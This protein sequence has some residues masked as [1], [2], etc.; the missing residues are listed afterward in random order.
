[1]KNSRLILGIVLSL[2]SVFGTTIGF[3]DTTSSGSESTT[4][5]SLTL[6]L[7]AAAA[8]DVTIN[9]TV[10]ASSTAKNYPTGYYDINLPNGVATITAGQTTTTIDFTVVDDTRDEDNE[11]VIIDIYAPTNATLDAAASQ[12]TYTINDNDNPPDMKFQ[13]STST[14]SEGAWATVTVELTAASG[15]TVTADWTL[16]DVTTSSSDYSTN[17]GTI[18]ITEGY[19]SYNFGI[20]LYDDGLDEDDESFTLSL[21]NFSNAGSASPST[22]E[23][24]ITDINDPPTVGFSSSSTSK[25]ESDGAVSVFVDLDNVSGRNVTVNYS[26]SGTATGSNIDHDLSAGTATITA[27]N[28]STTID[29]NI[30]Q[31]AL[32][33]DNETI[34][35]ILSSASNAT[36]G[37][38]DTMTVTILDDDASPFVSF[39]AASSSG[40]ESSSPADLTVTLNPVSGRSVQVNYTVTGGTASGSGTD[41][42]LSNGTLTFPAE[43]TSKNISAII[44]DDNLAEDNETIEVTISSPTNATLGTNTVHTYTINDNDS[45]PTIGFSSST[46]TSSEGDGQVGI[47]IALSAVSGQ[48]ITFDYAITGGTATSGSDYTFTPGAATISAGNSDTTITV[49]LIDDALDEID[50]ETIE[51]TI[52]NV[53]N[54]SLTNATH[55]KTITDNDNAPTVQFTSNPAASSGSEASSPV[56]LAVVIS[57][58]SAL[59][60]SVAY[61]IG[62]GSTATGSGTDYTLSSGTLTIPAGDSTGVISFTVNNDAL[63]ENDETV[64]VQ[65]SNPNNSTLGTRSSYTYTISDDDNSPDILF[66]SSSASGAENAT[67]VTIPVNITAVSG[68]GV[69]VDYTVTGGTALGSGTDYTL[70]DGSLTIPAGSTSDNISLTVVDDALDENSETIIVELSNP[71]NAGLGTTTLYTYTITD[72]DATPQIDFSSATGSVAE[73]AGTASITVVLNAVSGLDA[74][75]NYAVTGGDATG[76]GTDYTLASGIAT[77]TA[78]SNSTTIDVNITD[79]SMDERDE[80]LVISLSSPTN[81]TIGPDTTLTLTITDNDNPVKIAFSSS[82]SSVTENTS[83]SAVTVSLSAVSGVTTSVDYSVTDGTATG[84]G[85]DY[86]LSAGTV[87]IP[88]GDLSTTFDVSINDDNLDEDNETVIITLANP[89]SADL[90][91]RTNFTLTILDNDDSPTIQLSSSTSSASEGDGSTTFQLELSAIS[92]RDVMVDHVYTENEAL[93]AGVDF[94]LSVGTD[95]IS[96]GSLTSIFTLSLV[97]DALDEDDETM[98]VDIQNPVNASLG[99]NQSNTLTI[100]DNDPLPTVGFSASTASGDEATTSV[101]LNVVLSPVSGRTVTVEYSAGTGT[102]TGSGTDFSFTNGSLTFAAGETSKSLALTIADD[103]LDEVDE[104]VLIVLNNPGQASL[105]TDTLTYTIQDNDDPPVVA[106]DLVSST[107]LESVDSIYFDVSLTAASGKDVSVGYTVSSS[108]TASG[109]SVDYNLPAGTL[110]F[111]AGTTTRSILATIINDQLDEDNE[112]IIVE[113][114]DPPT[115]AT[116]GTNNAHTYTIIDNDASPVDFT[117]GSVRSQGTPSLAGFWNNSNTGLIV[118]V[119][120]DND[121]VL[122]SG[123]IQIRARSGSN[124]YRNLGSAYTILNSDLNDSASVPITQSEFEAFSDFAENAEIEFTAVITDIYG[125]STT[126]TASSETIII[127]TTPPG[128]FNTESFAAVGGLEVT[129]YWNGTNTSISA[130]VQ[131]QDDT[132]LPGGYVYL[133]G[134]I[135]NANYSQIGDSTGILSGDLNTS[136]TLTAPAADIQALTGYQAENV[137]LWLNSVII[138]RAGNQRTGN[139]SATLLQIDSNSPTVSQVSSPAANLAYK[140]G[141]SLVIQITATENIYVTGTPRLTLETGSSDASINYS[142]GS[143]STTIEFEYVVGA[144]QTSADLDYA[145]A[146]ALSLNGGTIRDVGGND[147]ILTLPV[148]GAAGSLSANNDIIIDTDAPAASL[149][150]ADSLVRFEDGS[151]LITATF[152]DSMSLDSVPKISVTFPGSGSPDISDASLTFVSGTVWQYNLGLIDNVDGTIIVSMTGKDKALNDLPGSSVSGGNILRIDNTDPVFTSVS[153]D[154]GSY[155]NH[156]QVGWT[157]SE[158]CYSGTVSFNNISGPGSSVSAAL[159]GSELSAGSRNPA[160]ITNSS[161]LTLVDGTVYRLVISGVDSAGNAGSISLANITYDTTAPTAELTYD[162]YYANSDTSVLITATFNERILPTPLISVNFAG[163]GQ[164][165]SDQAMTIG[166]DSTVWTFPLAIPIGTSNNGIASVTI[167]ATD[168]ALNT[169]RTQNLANRDT[170][171]I[172]NSAPAVSFSYENLSQPNLTNEGKGGDVIRITASFSEVTRNSP[173]PLLSVSYTDSTVAGIINTG[174]DG[175]STWTFDVTLRSETTLEEYLTVSVLAQDLAGNSITS[176]TD[177]DIFFLDNVSPSTFS[178][179]G[180]TSSGLNPVPGWINGKTDSIQVSVPVSSADATLLFGGKTDVQMT[181]PAR[182][183][184]G[185]WVTIGTA[186]SITQFGTLLAARSMVAIE[187]AFAGLASPIILAQGDTLYSRAVL[188]DR[189]GNV[190][191]GS[192]SARSLIY[193]PNAPVVG[194]LTGGNIVTNDTLRSTDS[195]TAIWTEFAEPSPATASGNAY[196]EVAVEHIGDATINGFM[197]WDSVGLILNGNYRL[198]L[199]HDNTYRMHIRAFDIAGNI[200]D[201]LSSNVIRRINSAPAIVLV[202]TQFVDEDIPLTV[203]LRAVD[204]DTATILGDTLHFIYDG[205]IGGGGTVYDNWAIDEISGI[206]T[207]ITPTQQDTG[208][209]RV[210]YS[211]MDEWGFV[212]TSSF[213]VTVISVNDTPQV[214][215]PPPSNAMSFIEDHTDIVQLNLTPFADDADNDS[216]QISWQAVILDT[217]TKNGYPLG[218]VV[219]GPG[220]NPGFV[221]RLE[222]LYSGSPFVKSRVAGFRSGVETTM[223]FAQ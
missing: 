169:L 90:G 24:T 180:I 150:Y 58:V 101:S 144:L 89:D 122:V 190:T 102:A 221:S 41:Y 31:D 78:G 110:V 93:G 170:L 5:V 115:N 7:D 129:G 118:R 103:G 34:L 96:A 151:V 17:S 185:N 142:G 212:D 148:P 216:T 188:T 76:G 77:V 114:T 105:G 28:G 143:G 195:L 62:T 1:M 189:V 53:T 198:P 38:A 141:D 88:P 152:T 119:P 191:N 10:N 205:P 98:R 179:G 59:D 35:I 79:D 163:I 82:S 156:K 197:D 108:S 211:V 137:G 217:T 72:N 71:T 125:N 218:I 149:S 154:T 124:S 112:T 222:R 83:P 16:T 25:N 173:A 203:Q 30:I 132:T 20:Y 36:L 69:S 130:T 63:D 186:D 106:F 26:V 61:G 73:N 134:G 54:A 14:N 176:V 214:V 86:T 139:V 164:D 2:N 199:Q 160:E 44:V 201:T 182:M 68:L 145:S 15:K 174:T 51:F 49:T 192:Q 116:M 66:S 85:T 64:I 111:S 23:M 18:T 165:V 47:T 184:T 121:N 208:S 178:T 172:D 84:S 146:T 127:D 67:S 123:Q 46:S 3:S 153:P 196:Y 74:A 131:V 194:A 113:L 219:A 161:D 100:T 19:T 48:N 21:S 56:N 32:D 43:V 162:Q 166:S 209:W 11:T 140:E 52:S 8:S 158:T 42:T 220:S 50:N 33:E 183:G 87:S 109:S 9:Y 181:I 94:T 126:G 135:D 65:L 117:V 22:H 204:V 136:M 99:T 147:L 207:W 138:D 107:G 128:I 81:A 60:V 4:S 39:N 177:N 167:S 40:A 223:P 27:G 168:L 92:G 13:T 37:S 29:F 45:P 133:L 12:A 202:D 210:Q 175:D 95:T 157:L 193:D 213:I 171:V 200:S 57:A 91:T 75:V 120:V 159:T 97:D 80:T 215:I 206:F 155:I 6:T 55:T 104:T 187:T 70:A